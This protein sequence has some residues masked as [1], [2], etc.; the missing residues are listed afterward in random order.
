MCIHVYCE[1]IMY[2]RSE[3]THSFVVSFLCTTVIRVSKFFNVFYEY[4]SYA[5]FFVVGVFVHN[6]IRSKFVLCEECIAH[7]CLL[8]SHNLDRVWVFKMFSG[9]YGLMT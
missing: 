3:C 7:I 5:Q 4:I 2:L 8:I 6:G 9:L 1:C